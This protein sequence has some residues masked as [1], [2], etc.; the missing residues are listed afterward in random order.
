MR[1]R[2]PNGRRA[3]TASCLLYSIQDGGT[4][5][6]TLK[7]IDVATGKSTSDEI[8]WVKT[9]AGDWT[10]D[11]SGFF[12]T[13]FPE[14]VAGQEFQSTNLNAKVYFHKLGTPQSADRLVYA[15]PDKPTYGHCA[16][17]SDDGRWLV[18]TTAEGTDDRY[19]VHA[20][21]LRARGAKPKALITG[22]DN[23][24]SFIGNEGSRFFFMTNKDAPKLKV[25]AMEVGRAGN[26]VTTLIPEQSAT[27]DGASVV[28]GKLVA[29]YLADA[30]SEVSVHNLQGKKLTS[31]ELPGIGTATGFSGEL[32]DPET[33][34]S[35]T[36]FNRPTTI[37]RYDVKSGQAATWAAPKVAFN[38]D[39][40][41]VE[42][43]FY[44]SKDGTRVPMFIVRKKGTTGP[45]PT[46]LY[47][48]GGFNVSLTPGFSATRLAWMEKGGVYALANLRGGGEY[49]KAWH[50]AGR[51]AQQA[52]RV[53]RFH[54][55]GR[56]SEGEQHRFTQGPRDP[57]R[58]ERRL[59]G[60]RGRQPASR[61]V[62]RGQCR[63]RRDGHAALRPVHRR[64]L[65]GRR[66]W[67]SR[68]KEADFRTL[69]AYSPYHNIKAGV[70]YP[71]RCW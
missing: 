70:H 12:Y 8:K 67:L 49:G 64:A 35:F 11:G 38:P 4:D 10:K 2:S 28:G 41:S 69:L 58:L 15:T 66:L 21:D 6:R 62:R 48:Y 45:A 65:L 17:V 3:R 1:P 25:V 23:N 31:V 68:N 29:S 16:T 34:F 56:I 60:R 30:K 57:G 9:S 40:Y 26:P 54:R 53:R 22:L 50:E 59:A 55:R 33:F 43:V 36:S 18:I 27:L 7:V 47:G 14:P 19:E 46:L 52:E 32:D 71:P 44:N 20:I 61:P 51:L 37:Y 13:R 39:E 63:G 42:Q 24:W 5:W